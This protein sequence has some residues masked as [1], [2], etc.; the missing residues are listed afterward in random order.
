MANHKSAEKRHRQS[1]KRK[2]RNKI[3]KTGVRGAVKKVRSAVDSAD[4]AAGQESLKLAEKLL[5]KAAAKGIIKKGTARRNT[6][7]LARK[8]ASVAKK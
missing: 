6:S 7:R 1:I 4:A 3:V 8:V 2:T 5:A